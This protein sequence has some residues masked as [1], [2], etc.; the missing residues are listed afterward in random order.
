MAC[1]VVNR[2]TLSLRSFSV[3]DSASVSPHSVLG[4]AG[5]VYNKAQSD[6][7]KTFASSLRIEDPD[8]SHGFTN[9]YELDTM[10][11]G[12]GFSTGPRKS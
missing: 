5:G 10:V 2:L 3:V 9:S 11:D 1:S 7:S 12:F 4:N 8:E 6:P